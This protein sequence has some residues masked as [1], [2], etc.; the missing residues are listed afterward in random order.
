MSSG[1]PLTVQLYLTLCFFCP[2]SA[3]L[4]RNLAGRR[5]TPGMGG[6]G[7]VGDSGD[8]MPS[9]DPSH[10]IARLRQSR[11]SSLF[12]HRGRWRPL[13]LGTVELV[14]SDVEMLTKLRVSRS[15][16]RTW[17][18]HHGQ[19]HRLQSPVFDLVVTKKRFDNASSGS[20]EQPL[21]FYSVSLSLSVR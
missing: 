15:G 12:R 7:C 10:L 13:E 19:Q 14:P 3:N 5:R 21:P 18:A 4:P 16:A 20:P 1:R 17:T 8:W 11:K 6:C 2:L 9:V